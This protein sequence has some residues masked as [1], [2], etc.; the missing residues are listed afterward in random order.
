MS[1][2]ALG[3]SRG[4]PCFTAM[5]GGR[6]PRDLLCLVSVFWF[7]ESRSAVVWLGVRV[8]SCKGTNVGQH[9][10]LATALMR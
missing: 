8:A 7:V 1:W 2:N 6:Y 10:A 4:A 9:G 3:I 5:Q